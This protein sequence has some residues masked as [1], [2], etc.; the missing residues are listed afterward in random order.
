MVWALLVV[1]TSRLVKLIDFRD[2]E[3]AV[4]PLPLRFTV[5]LPVVVLSVMV[6]AAVMEP[7]VEG[8]KVS[9]KVHSAPAAKALPQL[10]VWAKAEPL[11]PVIVMLEMFSVT[12]PVLVNVT[13][14]GALLVPTTWLP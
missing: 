13:V 6:N 9:V 7:V 10:S 1:P 4:V 14:C 12:V 11:A 3:T 8:V 2:K 5:W